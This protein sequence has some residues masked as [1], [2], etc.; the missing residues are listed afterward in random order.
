MNSQGEVEQLRMTELRQ[1]KRTRCSK[2]FR[3]NFNFVLFL[4]LF[5]LFLCFFL[6]LIFSLF[7]Y[8]ETWWNNY[9]KHDT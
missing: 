2:I 4:F 9:I 5:I 7:F 8:W 6:L 1:K 3:D